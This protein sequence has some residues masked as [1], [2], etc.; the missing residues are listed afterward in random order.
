MLNDYRKVHKQN[1]QKLLNN[2]IAAAIDKSDFKL[3]ELLLG[4]QKIYADVNKGF[5]Y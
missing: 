5:K 4:E 3:L 1:I 2:R